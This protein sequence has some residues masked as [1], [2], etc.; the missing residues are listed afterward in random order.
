MANRRPRTL[1]ETERNDSERNQVNIISID[2]K[3][4]TIYAQVNGCRITAVCREQANPD[5]YDRVKGI[6][7]G[8]LS[9]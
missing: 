7:I 2:R 1:P 9:H 4:H 6:L 5:V 3:N 8:S